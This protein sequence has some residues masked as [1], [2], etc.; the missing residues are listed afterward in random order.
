[1]F[2]LCTELSHT[3]KMHEGRLIVEHEDEKTRKQHKNR[4][5][6]DIEL[7][8]HQEAE[9][10]QSQNNE[11]KDKT[12]Q[13]KESNNK[14]TDEKKP[15]SRSKDKKN[16][17]EERG[18]GIFVAVQVPRQ[19]IQSKGEWQTVEGKGIYWVGDE[20]PIAEGDLV[21]FTSVSLLSLDEFSTAI[22]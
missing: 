22:K 18:K 12:M 20:E 13:S 10:T 2:F 4:T 5:T 11:K 7:I 16:K 8:S 17:M 3:L 1:M 6:F 9:E 15:I 14:N 19:S 21:T